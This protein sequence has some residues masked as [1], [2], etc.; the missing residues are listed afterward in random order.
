MSVLSV[1]IHLERYSTY[2]REIQ[3]VKA[4]PRILH[5]VPNQVAASGQSAHSLCKPSLIKE[6]QSDRSSI[7]PAV[8]NLSAFKPYPEGRTY[9]VTLDVSCLHW[10]QSHRPYTKHEPLDISASRRLSLDSALYG[11]YLTLLFT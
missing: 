5:N 1:Y 10:V 6:V 9:L 3:V 7:Q 4:E 11:L 2:R 8:E